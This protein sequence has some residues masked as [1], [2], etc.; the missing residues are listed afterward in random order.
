MSFWFV[1]RSLLLIFVYPSLI[2]LC[3]YSFYSKVNRREKAIQK[4][5]LELMNI[6]E[7]YRRSQ[8]D[9]RP[10]TKRRSIRRQSS[11]PSIFQEFENLKLGSLRRRRS[12]SALP[13]LWF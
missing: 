9:V 12:S 2:C 10:K 5:E 13:M 11:S 8:D 1:R 3:T 4:L 7:N 6:Q